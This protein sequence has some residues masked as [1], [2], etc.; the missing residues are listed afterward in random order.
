MPGILDDF[1]LLQLAL[2]AL[3]ATLAA[4]VGGVAGYGTG[5]LMPIVLVPIVGPEP[6]V[7]IMALA[8]LLINA[9]RVAAFRSAGI[10]AAA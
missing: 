1:S 4:V 10:R 7:P 2:I 8:A 5:L 3:A 9:S 6:V